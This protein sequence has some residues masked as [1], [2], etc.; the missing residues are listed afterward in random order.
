MGEFQSITVRQIR[1]NL[2]IEG[3]LERK[4]TRWETNLLWFSEFRFDLIIIECKN[5]VM[6]HVPVSNRRPFMAVGFWKERNLQLLS[7]ISSFVTSFYA[8]YKIHLM[9]ILKWMMVLAEVNNKNS[10]N[11]F[12]HSGNI[13]NDWRCCWFYQQI[14]VHDNEVNPKALKLTV[15]F[16]C[17]WLRGFEPWFC[18]HARCQFLYLFICLDKGL[19][20]STSMMLLVTQEVKKL[21]PMTQDVTFKI[22][23]SLLVSNNTDGINFV[24][25]S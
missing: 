3:K 2:I 25:K 8:S 17:R 19:P 16:F 4:L 5:R 6:K 1:F 24:D 21:V 22:G 20:H 12:I 11:C 9:F 7:A 10:S 23:Y 18:P 13:V 15:A 14:G